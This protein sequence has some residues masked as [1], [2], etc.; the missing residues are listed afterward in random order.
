VTSSPGADSQALPSSREMGEGLQPAILTPGYRAPESRRTISGLALAGLVLIA[1]VIAVALHHNGHTLGDDFAL[2]L[3]QARS[4]FDGNIGEVVADNRFSV[5]YSTGQFSPY[6]YPWGWPLLLSPF[7]HVW[8]LDYDR[9]KLVEVAAFCV[10]LVLVH[11]IIRRRAGR[12]MALGVTAIVATAPMLLT[13]TDQLLSE[14]PAA[15]AVAV[16]IWWW[17]RVRARHPLTAADPRE[18]VVLGVLAAVAFNV[19]REAIVLVV[20]IAIIQVAEL[21][22]LVRRRRTSALNLQWRA[23]LTPHVAFVASAV[24]IQLLLP[25]MLFPDQDDHFGNIGARLGDYSGSLTEQL[26]L[27][28]HPALGVF[29]IGLAVVGMIV[30]CRRRPGLD[31]PLTAITVLTVLTVSTHFRLVDR[32]YFQV[33]PWMV[34]FGAV[35]VAEAF[36]LALRSRGGARHATQLAVLPLVY[37]LVVHAFVLPGDIADARDFND[38]GRQQY[39]PT[40]PE[41]PPIFDAVARYTRPDDVIA[42]FRARTMTLYTDRRS[43]QT[44]DINRVLA[45]ADFYA[46]LRGSGYYQP[47]V[48]MEEATNMGLTMVWSDSYWVLWR[49]PPAAG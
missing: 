9:L 26:G 40:S 23:V 38:G 5:L 48:S 13:H 24:L 19:R 47:P 10:W 14:Y 17:D 16:A 30:G 12:A 2:Y 4:I 3:R 42:Y 11:G 32:Y 35:A 8:G 39:G 25:S 45:V 33:L 27:G 7:V 28:S 20:A 36:G 15:V 44:T 41:F 46:Q 1:G 43:I 37:L 6:A 18:L 29:I 34:Y 49:V 31:G 22:G 21:I